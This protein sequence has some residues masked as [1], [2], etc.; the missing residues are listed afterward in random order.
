MSYYLSGKRMKSET[1]EFMDKRYRAYVCFRIL[2][3]VYRFV[4]FELHHVNTPSPLKFK[5]EGLFT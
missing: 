5:G 1:N 4:P 2:S 3:N